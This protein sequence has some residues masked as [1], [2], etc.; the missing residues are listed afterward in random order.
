MLCSSCRKGG[1]IAMIGLAK[2]NNWC[3][4]M[5]GNSQA[6]KKFI[7]AVQ[8]NSLLKAVLCHSSDF[9]K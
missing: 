9:P 5:T 6:E 4:I 7:R 2:V 3:V 1:K 8:D